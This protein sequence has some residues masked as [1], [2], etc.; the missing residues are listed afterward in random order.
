M[1]SERETGLLRLNALILLHGNVVQS[2]LEKIPGLRLR[3]HSVLTSL[4]VR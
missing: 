3:I 1:R 2:S 4:T